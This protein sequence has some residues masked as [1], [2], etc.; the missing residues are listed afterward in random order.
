MTSDIIEA[1]I[2]CTPKIHKL[3][4]ISEIESQSFIMGMALK[5]QLNQINDIT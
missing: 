1:F 5:D 3:I 2:Q 4:F